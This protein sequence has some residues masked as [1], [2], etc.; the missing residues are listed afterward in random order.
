MNMDRDFSNTKP[1]R[2]G[3]HHGQEKEGVS[4]DQQTRKIE[5]TQSVDSNC[6]KR[7]G[8]FRKLDLQQL[9]D[10][11]VGRLAEPSAVPSIIG[12]PTFNIARANDKIVAVMQFLQQ[13][14][15]LSRVMSMIAIRGN[16]RVIVVMQGIT[17]G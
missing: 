11:R 7:S 15:N 13:H 9:A 16:Q 17:P 5:F 12:A 3:M 4:A 6:S 14:G 2:V 10:R 8:K 1:A